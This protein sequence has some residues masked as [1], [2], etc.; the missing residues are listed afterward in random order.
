MGQ[1]H[2]HKPRWVNDFLGD[3]PAKPMSLSNLIITRYLL[4]VCA[5]ISDGHPHHP[6]L[7]THP[8]PLPRLHSTTPVRPYT[9]P[10]LHSPYPPPYPHPILTLYS[11]L[12]DL[13]GH[14]RCVPPL[15]VQILLFWHAKFSKCSHFGGPRPPV[16]GPRPPPPTGNPGSATA[17]PHPWN[18]SRH[19]LAHCHN[20][21]YCTT[22]Q[23]HWP[24]LMC[25]L[26]QWANDPWSFFA[27]KVI[28]SKHEVNLRT[29]TEMS[30]TF[31]STL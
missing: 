9:Y 7:S 2:T 24:L 15:R 1:L 6:Y 29:N 8:Y 30:E 19:L 28:F 17:H 27:I 25:M 16:R 4:S 31:C 11:P 12:A 14:T 18:S 20:N 3:L 13:G 22:Q 5:H 10:P 21:W 23:D 26:C